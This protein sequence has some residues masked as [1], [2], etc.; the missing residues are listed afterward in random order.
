[1]RRELIGREGG[2][3]VILILFTRPWGIYFRVRDHRV[4]LGP[5]FGGR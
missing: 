1:M 3:G 2:T 5:R 4:G